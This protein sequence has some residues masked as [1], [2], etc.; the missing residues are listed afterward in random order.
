MS[1]NPMMPFLGKLVEVQ[2]LASEIKLLRVELQNGGGAGF[3]NYQPGQFA[4][5]SAFGLGEAPF[6][7]ANAAG[8]GPLLDF[9]VARLG[10][11]TTGLHE[12][13]QGH[14]RRSVLHSYAIRIKIHIRFTALIR[15]P[16][17]RL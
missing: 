13:Q 2:D 9:A 10:S 11:V 6:G 16:G 7:I 8:R 14:L 12:L 5:V 1:A 4:F 15:S 17:H 3:Q